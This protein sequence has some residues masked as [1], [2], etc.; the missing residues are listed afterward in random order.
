MKS[1]DRELF[2]DQLKGVAIVGVVYIHSLSLISH[3]SY[4]ALFTSD[5]F[6]ISVPFFIVTGGTKKEWGGDVN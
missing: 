4:A 5:L 2:Y 1:S 6:R 3:P